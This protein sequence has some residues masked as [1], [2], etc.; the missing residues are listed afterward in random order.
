MA[1]QGCSERG[2][3]WGRIGGK[4]GRGRVKRWGRTEEERGGGVTSPIFVLSRPLEP[5]LANEASKVLQQGLVHNKLAVG[6]PRAMGLPTGFANVLC[7][8][9]QFT[10]PPP[11]PPPPL[12]NFRDCPIGETKFIC[13]V[14][15]FVSA[16]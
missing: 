11:P 14:M 10:Y 6:K 9:W 8:T 3:G 13:L 15:R 2:R 7:N 1:H 4:E 16:Y 12:S 5:Q